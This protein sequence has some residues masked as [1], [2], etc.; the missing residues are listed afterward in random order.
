MS[1]DRA[2][3]TVSFSLFR[4]PLDTL[5]TALTNEIEREFPKK[6]SAVRGLQPFL[7]IL[8]A[9]TRNT[10]DAIRFLVADI[11]KDSRPKAEYGLATAPLVRT[12]ADL[13]STLVFMSENFTKRADWFH[14]AGWR[15][16]RE[17]YDRHL[18]EYGS[19][20]EWI[21]YLTNYST[22]L[23]AL[24]TRIGI[25]PAEASSPGEIDYWPTPPQMLAKDSP[26]QPHKRVFLEYVRDWL[27]RGLS[28]KSHM[29]GAGISHAHGLLLL[30]DED[31]RQERLEKFKS[32]A[33]FTAITLVLCLCSEL[34]SIC[35]FSH[36][37]QLSYIWRLLNE[38]WGEAKD[39][40]DRRY[41]ALVKV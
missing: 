41:M 37:S 8:I 40:F 14:R 20:T 21:P 39:L 10:Y 25:T 33:V 11:P 12:L 6:F 7:L 36:D 9:V 34:N 31:G 23:D 38:H 2:I 5:L 35:G 22:E 17:D 3:Q 30:K 18:N 4:D 19:L 26:I 24:A 15:E 32:D 16:L 27:Y 13:L 29:S 1:G 28:Q